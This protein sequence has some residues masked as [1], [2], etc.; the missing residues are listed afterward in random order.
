MTKICLCSIMR[1]ESKIVKRQL[2]SIKEVV[3][4]ISICDTGSEDNTV[5]LIKEWGKENNVPTAVHFEP[6]QN[7]G[8]N[9]T[10]SFQMAKK[11]FPD[12][13]YCLFLD[14]DMILK[15][16]P[17]WAKI[18][19]KLTLGSYTIK[20]T[21]PRIAYYNL[22]L[23]S[24]K[25]DFKCIGVT[26][27]YWTGGD[28]CEGGVLE[29]LWIDDRDDGGHK[30]NKLTRDRDL[31]VAGLE[32]PNTPDDLKGRYEHYLAQTYRGLGQFPKAIAHYNRRIEIGG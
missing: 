4:C 14:A 31:L 6:F 12:A 21:N 22:R 18:K 25:Y 7:F 3:D 26:H 27:E 13:D 16:E 1:N 29:E 23:A 20:Q 30:A 17:G 24:T 15:I 28:G 8:Y 19:D 10:L 2:D 9:R 5:E 32:D 11:S